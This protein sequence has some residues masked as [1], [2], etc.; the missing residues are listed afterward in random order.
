M[1]KKKILVVTPR[2]PYPI[3]GADEQDRAG[4]ILQFKRLGYDGMVVAKYFDW[5]PKEEIQ[6]WAQKE[7]IALKLVPY[8][9]GTKH[10]LLLRHPFCL[11]GSA[12]EYFDPD[13]IAAVEQAIDQFSPDLVWFDYTYLWPLY[14]LAKRKNIP[15]VV[16]SINNEARHYLQED[17]VTPLHLLK[18]IPKYLTEWKTAQ[19]ADILFAITPREEKTYRHLGA[20]QVA[21]LPL[22]GLAHEFPRHVPQDREVLH[23]FFFGSTYTV[24]HNRRALAFILTALAPRVYEEWGEKYQFHIFGAKFPPDLEPALR[25]LEPTVSYEGFAPDLDQALRD[26]DIAVVPSFFGAGMQQKIFEPLRRGFPT[27]THARGLADYDFHSGKE[28]LTAATLDEY[29]GTLRQLRS[30]DLRKTLSANAFEKSQAL[31]SR[32]AND[33]IITHHLD[34]L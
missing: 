34:A 32:S 25:A 30:Y 14:P 20:H 22:R 21:T 31:F 12:L 8:I 5:Q 26:M 15:M 9:Q 2:F 13:M 11:D 23:I 27:I 1:H 16:R 4:G 18:A 33:D 3:S 10:S 29:L 17:G 6:A 7:N 19:A 24:S 28:L